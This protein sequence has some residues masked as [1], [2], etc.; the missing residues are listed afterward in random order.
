MIASV[1]EKA[2]VGFGTASDFYERG[3]PEYPKDAVDRLIHE[4]AIVPGTTVVDVGAGTGKFTRLLASS[5]ARIIAV[6]P[7]EGMRRKLAAV[8]P[9]IEVRDGS[10]E[11]IPLPSGSADSLTAAQA[12]HWF[13]GE[14]ALAEFRRVLRPGGGL[15][16]IWNLR[17]DSVDWM[18][19]LGRIYE[20]YE[21]GTPRYKSGEWQHAF[22][23]TSLFAPLRHCEFAHTQI[24]TV[25]TLVDRVASASFIAALPD[26]TRVQ[27][28][29]EVRAL[30]REHPETRG[31]EFIHIPYRTDLFLT[32]A[33]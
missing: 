17:D 19:C 14:E 12:F 31:K 26:E 4:L 24:G 23:A 8:C 18:A 28:L 22:A 27:V 9:W 20:R 11:Q 13:R 2:V 1:H 33:L 25:Q 5:G 16:L 15:G 7:V 32:Y 30:V 10:A 6:E 21:G 29:E 3:R